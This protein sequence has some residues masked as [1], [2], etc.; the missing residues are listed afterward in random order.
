MM[1]ACGPVAMVLS[2]ESSTRTRDSRL[3]TR[4]DARDGLPGP[5][6]STSTLTGPG[7]HVRAEPLGSVLCSGSRE[8]SVRGRGG[9]LLDLFNLCAVCMNKLLSIYKEPGLEVPSLYL[10]HHFPG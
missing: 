9:G 3:H 7:A 2:A 5:G 6:L 1:E 4:S 10:T 8:G